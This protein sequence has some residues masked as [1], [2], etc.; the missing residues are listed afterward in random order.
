MN[1]VFTEIK[2]LCTTPQSRLAFNRLL[3]TFA[4]KPTLQI[5]MK[6]LYKLADAYKEGSISKGEYFLVKEMIGTSGV[7]VI[8]DED[9]EFPST[10]YRHN[11]EIDEKPL[12]YF[13]DIVRDGDAVLLHI[14]GEGAP[15]AI[16]IKKQALRKYFK[17]VNFSG[18]DLPDEGEETEE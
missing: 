3:D 18:E 4:I 14:H 1:K 17:L 11:D 16:A 8:T 12:L 15:L 9:I 7:I 13:A 6:Q 10:M 2:R 5:D